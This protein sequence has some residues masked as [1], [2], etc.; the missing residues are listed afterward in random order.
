MKMK[1]VLS[2]VFLS[3]LMAVFFF[4]QL[5]R[6]K[7][8]E[9]KE[10]VFESEDNLMITADLYM[11]NKSKAPYIILFHQAGYSRGEYNSIAPVLNKMGFNCLAIDQRAGR[12]A[13]GVENSTAK[14]AKALKLRTYYQDALPDMEASLKYIKDELKAEK[15]IIWGSS[16]SAALVFVLG[17]KY[18]E[19]IKGILA[20]S[21]G[22]YM[23]IEGR[24]IEDYA[25][26]IKCPVFITST[27]S[28]EEEWKPIYEKIPSESKTYYVPS[29]FPGHHGSSALWEDYD[30][31]SF[32]WENVEKF[33]NTLK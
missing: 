18:P 20:F 19:D 12:S 5:S 33:L 27:Q 11:T 8:L 25:K 13:R 21:P 22:E 16:Y 9:P 15:I 7:V 3:A 28:E 10:V 4:V 30:K 14:Q 1:V 2:L 24:K 31:S 17:E 23:K 6:V 29:D 32:Y 26:N